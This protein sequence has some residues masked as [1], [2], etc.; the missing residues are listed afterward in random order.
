ME[1][2]KASKDKAIDYT[3]EGILAAKEKRK[4]V[5]PAG[6]EP[7]GVEPAG[8][9][10]RVHTKTTPGS[11][12]ESPPKRRRFQRVQDATPAPDDQWWVSSNSFKVPDQALFEQDDKGDVYQIVD[13]GTDGTLAVVEYMNSADMFSAVVLEVQQDEGTATVQNERTGDTEEGVGLRR[14][15]SRVQNPQD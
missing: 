2:L 15:I 14:F 10:K 5:E 11:T 7:A 6:V 9:R 8:A 3:T 12:G 1:D 4:S 13:P